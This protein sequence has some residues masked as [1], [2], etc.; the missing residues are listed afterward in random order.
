ME[1][2]VVFVVTNASKQA[3][4]DAL[5]RA[6]REISLCLRDVDEAPRDAISMDK[7]SH[8]AFDVRRVQV[9]FIPAV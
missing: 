4:R 5:Y 7:A 8:D 3:P 6:C 2:V 9:T 1:R